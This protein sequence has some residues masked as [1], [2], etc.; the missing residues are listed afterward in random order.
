M[1]HS[2]GFVRS[3]GMDKN[4]PIRIKKI[5]EMS[6]E[7]M[8]RLLHAMLTFEGEPENELTS[9]HEWGSIESWGK[10]PQ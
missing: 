3:S 4:K 9:G 6:V 8:D 7:E 2:G 5:K 10:E 1:T